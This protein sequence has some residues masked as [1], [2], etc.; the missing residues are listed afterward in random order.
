M[1]MKT[2]SVSVCVFE[3]CFVGSNS[4]SSIL[5]LCINM[6]LTLSSFIIFMC[7]VLPYTHKEDLAHQF[8]AMAALVATNSALSVLDDETFN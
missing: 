3:L 6:T 1:T 8:R 7:T 4:S 2:T 5:L